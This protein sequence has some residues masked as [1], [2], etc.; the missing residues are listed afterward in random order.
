MLFITQLHPEP[1]L[2]V[3]CFTSPFASVVRFDTEVSY[4]YLA[5][6]W[7]SQ[8][9]LGTGTL[10][11][12]FQF[13]TFPTNITYIILVKPNLLVKYRPLRTKKK[14]KTV[15]WIAFCDCLFWKKL[16]FVGL[17]ITS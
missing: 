14:K 5:L 13:F 11:L 15:L 6:L 3:W 4:L 17:S 16:M 7:L 2:V 10:Q 1:S 12:K 9:S 8:I